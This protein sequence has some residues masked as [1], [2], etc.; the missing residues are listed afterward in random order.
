MTSR[1]T[2]R[3]TTR[4]A[5]SYDCGEGARGL[6]A[7][8]RKVVFNAD[9]D[10]KIRTAAQEVIQHLD[11][12]LQECGTLEEVVAQAGDEPGAVAVVSIG[13]LKALRERANDHVEIAREL[14]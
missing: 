7:M 9:S 10:P 12:D 8:N 2:T 3:L 13:T 14:D 5:A 1:R 6:G 11:G 4:D